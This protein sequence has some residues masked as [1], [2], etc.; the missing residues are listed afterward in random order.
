M[1]ASGLKA[2][3]DKY[4]DVKGLL[5]DK[6]DHTSYKINYV[7]AYVK[8]WLY[9]LANRKNAT[10][11]NFIDCMCNAGIYTDGELG[12]PIKSLEHIRDAAYA[13]PNVQFHVFLN[14]YDNDRLTVIKE[15][16]AEILGTAPKNLTVHFDNKDVN[17]YLEEVSTFRNQCGVF[18]ALTLLYVDP[19]NFGTVKLKNIKNFLSKYYSELIFNVFT[20]DFRR[21]GKSEINGKKIQECMTGCDLSQ[22]KNVEQLVALIDDQLT[23]GHIKYTFRYEFR[24]QTNSELYQIMFC[25]PNFKGIEQLKKALWEVFKGAKFHRNQKCIDS[26]QISLFEFLPDYNEEKVLLNDRAYEAR[27]MLIDHY[28]T[29]NVYIPYKDI[30]EFIQCRTML[31]QSHIKDNVLIPLLNEGRLKKITRADKRA[32]NYTEA[33][34]IFTTGGAK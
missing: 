4:K 34:Y 7:S 15:V 19:Y 5:D 14:D 10:T 25:T 24:T 1:S 8:E 20:S 32:N 2:I 21:N 30:N 16:V 33:D 3:Y 6:K 27:K 18:N 11:V 9:V 26:G 12:T 29:A 31:K 22:I 28:E 17:E 13:H 23:T